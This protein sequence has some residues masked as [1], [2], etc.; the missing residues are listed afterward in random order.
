MNGSGRCSV[1]FPVKR[2]AS[3]AG[4]VTA[5]H[6]GTV[7]TTTTGVNQQAQ[8]TFQ[9]S[10]FPGRDYAWVATNANWTPRNLVNGYG[11]A[12]VTVAGSTQAL[13]G[14]SICRSGSTTGWRCGTV[15]QLNTSV[16]Y[17]QGTVSGVTRTSVCAEPGDSGGSF[18]SGNQAQGMTS[19]GSGNCSQGGTTYFQ[20]LAPAL[21]AYGLTLVTGNDGGGPGPT[22]PP[23]EPGGTW[24]AGTAYAVGA[25]VTYGGTTYRCL[26]AHTA[27][28]GWQPPNTPSLWQRV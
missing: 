10:T 25:T 24:A 17:P 26:Q 14:A 16:T 5:G 20:P 15:Q 7:G 9:G 11:N 3:Q 18:I 12:D 1:G 13:V 19:G 21:S 2:G 28:A 6:C 8:G 27:Q 4:F 22:D 23:T